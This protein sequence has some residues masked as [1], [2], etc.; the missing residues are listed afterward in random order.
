[1][2][3]TLEDPKYKETPELQERRARL[4][5]KARALMHAIQEER[6]KREGDCHGAYVQDNMAQRRNQSEH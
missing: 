2:I 3:H 5:G 1:M 6:D 4:L